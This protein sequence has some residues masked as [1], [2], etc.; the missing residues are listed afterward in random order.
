MLLVL[1]EYVKEI[2]P[3][4]Y[5]SKTGKIPP[6][7]LVHARSDNQVPYNN[8]V[9][10]KTVLGYASVPHKMLTPT[11]SGNNHMLGGVVYADNSPVVFINQNWVSEA[12][13]WVE[14]YLQ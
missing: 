9:R 7:L 1:K 12:K 6:T 11:G 5:V 3:I 8:A 10:L 2:S 14:T 4:I 13:K